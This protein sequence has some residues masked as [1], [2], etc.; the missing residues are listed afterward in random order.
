MAGQSYKKL[1]LLILKL[2]CLDE[3]RNEKKLLLIE[4][5]KIVVELPEPCIENWAVFYSYH[6]PKSGSYERRISTCCVL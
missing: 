3:A 2:F 4:E 6:C 5:G 1:Y